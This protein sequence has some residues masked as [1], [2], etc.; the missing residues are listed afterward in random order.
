ME[1]LRISQN[2]RFALRVGYKLWFRDGDN[3]YLSS[4][5]DGLPGSRFLEIPN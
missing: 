5:I 3:A 2:D 1:L 4:I